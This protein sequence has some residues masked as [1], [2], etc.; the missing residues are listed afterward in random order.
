MRTLTINVT[1]EDIDKGIKESCFSCP[2][3]KALRRVMSNSTYI[4]V[5]NPTVTVGSCTTQLPIVAS[6]FISKFDIDQPVSPFTFDL[7]L[8]D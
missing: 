6:H 4:R 5:G 2:V 3:A 8:A 7:T 1:Q